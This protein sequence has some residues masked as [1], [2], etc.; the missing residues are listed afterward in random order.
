MVLKTISIR[1]CV[2]FFTGCCKGKQCTVVKFQCMVK[3]FFP[4]PGCLLGKGDL[5]TETNGKALIHL[6]MNVHSS[7][8]QAVCLAS[9]LSQL[10][11]AVCFR[12]RFG[13]GDR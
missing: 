4:L 10:C 8:I 12:C 5:Q 1:I 9:G 13:G 6:Q 3:V 7:V 11:G 2:I